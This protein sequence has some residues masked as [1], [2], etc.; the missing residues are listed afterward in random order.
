MSLVCAV[1]EDR[2]LLGLLGRA[3][4]DAGYAVDAY[5]APGPMLQAV[6]QRRY[7][8]VLLDATHSGRDRA[9]LDALRTRTPATLVM[10]LASGTDSAYRVHYLDAGAC[11]V[12]GKP[13]DLSELLARARAH[14]RRL[15]TPAPATYLKRAPYGAGRGS[16]PAKPAE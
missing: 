14:L 9:T 7:D 13:F 6:A 11:D 1:A 16:A 3:F 2:A 12:V 15:E 10:V 4:R 8:L 5:S